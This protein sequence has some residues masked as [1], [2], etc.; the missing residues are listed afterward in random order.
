MT[1]IASVLGANQR[2]LTA[3]A[4]RALACFVFVAATRVEAAVC[5]SGDLARIAAGK[6]LGIRPTFRVLEIGKS[7]TPKLQPP[8]ARWLL[9]IIENSYWRHYLPGLWFV[10]EASDTRPLIVFY[11]SAEPLPDATVQ[12]I[13]SKCGTRVALWSDLDVVQGPAGGGVVPH[14]TRDP[15]SPD[16][17][18]AP[19]L[20]RN[21]NPGSTAPLPL[22]KAV[23]EMAGL[24][25]ASS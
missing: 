4:L 7:G 5:A 11:S 18:G 17:A 20:P 10:P 9:E 8:E 15:L 16:H 1:R 25:P 22:V 12:I 21:N 2:R 24:S 3:V 13:G 23:R 19:P 6:T 14:C